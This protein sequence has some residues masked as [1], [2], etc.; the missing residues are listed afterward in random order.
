MNKQRLIKLLFAFIFIIQ[1]CDCQRGEIRRDHRERY[2]DRS[3]NRT[4]RNPYQVE[5]NIGEN[6]FWPHGQNGRNSEPKK[7]FNPEKFRSSKH[8]HPPVPSSRDWSRNFEKIGNGEEYNSDKR[9]KNR[10]HKRRPKRHS[11]LLGI[12]FHLI[13]F[14][15]GILLI[16]LVIVAIVKIVNK[17]IMKRKSKLFPNI[18][19]PEPINYV[20]QNPPQLIVQDLAQLNKNSNQIAFNEPRSEVEYPKLNR[21]TTVAEDFM[22][23]NNRKCCSNIIS[24]DSDV[25]YHLLK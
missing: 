9:R 15:V 4:D 13:I 17:Y 5:H 11:R 19:L 10:S 7:N 2:G 8:S 16:A 25:N 14:V 12:I 23:V 20:F 21:L 1:L 24:D 18:N 6:K 22:F 3:I